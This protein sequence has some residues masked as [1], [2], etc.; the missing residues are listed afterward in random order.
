MLRPNSPANRSHRPLMSGRSAYSSLKLSPNIPSGT[1]PVRASRLCRH[2]FRSPFTILRNNVSAPTLPGDARLAISSFTSNH[3]LFAR[4]RPPLSRFSPHPRMKYPFRFL[5]DIEGR[6][7]SPRRFFL[8]PSSQLWFGA[9][10]TYTRRLPHRLNQSSK[11]CP[12]QICP[13]L[14]LPYP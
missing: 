8:L 5:P 7:F 6:Q 3:I 10:I 12:Q 14:A 13:G 9:L 2:P 4:C 11:P 1:D